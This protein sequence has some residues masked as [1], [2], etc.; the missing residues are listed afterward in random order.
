LWGGGRKETVIAGIQI[1]SQTFT[2]DK[3]KTGFSIILGLVMME[4]SQISHIP[5]FLA[6]PHK[7]STK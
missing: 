5:I 3:I 4:K 1:L 7:T 2:H 6:P